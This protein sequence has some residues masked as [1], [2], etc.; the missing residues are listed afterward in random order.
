MDSP[1][2]YPNYSAETEGDR[3]YW[4]PERR[5]TIR[6]NAVNATLGWQWRRRQVH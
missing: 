5:V 6:Q 3:L 1:G 4:P 2:T